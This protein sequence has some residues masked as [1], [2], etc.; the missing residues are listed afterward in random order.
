[1]WSRH[2]GGITVR[3]QRMEGERY[4]TAGDLT[5]ERK[6]KVP[7]ARER[8]VGKGK[9]GCR[10]GGWREIGD[11]DVGGVRGTVCV[12]LW[13]GVREWSSGKFGGES[14]ETFKKEGKGKRGFVGDSGYC[15]WEG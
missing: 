9:D 3:V 15:I 10:M 8:D 7:E 5:G 2:S 13:L 12:C 1:M 6:G 11:D 4:R 14:G